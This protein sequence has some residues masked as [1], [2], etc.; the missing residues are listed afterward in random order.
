MSRGNPRPPLRALEIFAVAARLG[1]FTAA[2]AELGITQSAVSRQIADLES[3]LGIQLFERRGAH[4]AATPAGKRLAT[5]LTAAFADVRAALAE[6]AASDRVITLS[7]LPSV[8]AKWFAPRLD[9]FVL[10][11]PEIDLR[12]TASRHLVDFASEGVDA[13][14][15][16]GVGPWSGLKAEKLANETITPVCSPA[17]ARQI[18]LMS[19]ADLARAVLLQ[20]DIP[21]NWEAW[22]RAAGCA[23]DFTAGPRLGDDAAILQAVLNDNGVALGRSRLVADDIASGKLIQ[24]F[25]VHLTASHAYWFVWPQT[26]ETTIALSSVESWIK[27]EFS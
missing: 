25:D 10:A 5:R 2:G 24:P 23:I 26:T 17:Y 21:E 9:R 1:G 3:V 7:M 13:A 4:V 20:G 19:P 8:A 11:H 15:R 18:G 27:Q 16:Y 22:F 6:A 14:I 12:I